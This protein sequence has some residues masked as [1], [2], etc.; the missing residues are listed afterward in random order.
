MN[1]LTVAV[2]AVIASAGLIQVSHAQ[3]AAPGQVMTY[4][5]G[6]QSCGMWVNSRDE[7]KR[8]QPSA[9]ADLM[10]SWVEGYVSAYQDAETNR[11]TFKVTDSDGL[12]VAIDQYCTRHPTNT[13]RLAAVTLVGE[14]AVTADQQ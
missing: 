9:V 13:L 11:H 5:I 2:A 7:Q 3:K 10:F 6:N 12:E 4:G 1:K 14:L 8:G